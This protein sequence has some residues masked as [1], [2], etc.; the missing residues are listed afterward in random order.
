MKSGNAFTVG[1]VQLA[2]ARA[3]S[4]TA[5]ATLATRSSATRQA[6]ISPKPSSMA[7]RRP[8]RTPIAPA[9]N[10]PI[11]PPIAQAMKPIVTSSPRTPK[12]SVPCS[13]N[14][15]V[16]VWKISW[17]RNEATKMARSPG[18]LPRTASHAAP[19]SDRNVASVAGA[20]DGSRPRRP[21]ANATAIARTV[22]AATMKATRMPS[23]RPSI[24]KTMAPTH[25]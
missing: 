5:C 15:V 19:A 25:I 24:R 4:G 1:S 11:T 16:K 21:A 14:Q 18:T 3:S 13:A 2:D 9:G 10:A 17:S 23:I 6:N 12:R 8:M 22:A 7:R 20:P